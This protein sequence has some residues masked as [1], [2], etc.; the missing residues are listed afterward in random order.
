M[1]FK[2]ALILGPDDPDSPIIPTQLNFECRVE[3]RQRADT[4]FLSSLNAH[5][6]FANFSFALEIYPDSS[7]SEPYRFE[8][9]P[10]DVKVGDMVYFEGTVVT[11]NELDLFLETCWATPSADPFDDISYSLIEDG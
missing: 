6:A 11:V 4:S 8:D 2:N 9:Y 3:R 5:V 1:V 7:F 10:I